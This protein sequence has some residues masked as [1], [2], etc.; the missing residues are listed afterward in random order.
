MIQTINIVLSLFWNLLSKIY[1]QKELV[2]NEIIQ[3][4]SKCDISI[5]IWDLVDYN[6]CFYYY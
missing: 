4:N 3:I 2:L 6:L 1:L 5:N